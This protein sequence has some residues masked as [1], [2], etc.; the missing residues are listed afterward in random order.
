M[1]KAK[2]ERIT[3]KPIGIMFVVYGLLM[4]LFITLGICFNECRDAS[5]IWIIVIL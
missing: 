2:E 3:F 4:S 1:S 5:A